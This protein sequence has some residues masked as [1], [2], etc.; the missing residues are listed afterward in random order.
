MRNK[1]FLL[2]LGGLLSAAPLL[3]AQSNEIGLQLGRTIHEGRRFE[4]AGLPQNVFK[5]DNGWAGGLVY[6]RK[7]LGGKGAALNLHVPFFLL[8]DRIP[9]PNRFAQSS[10]DSSKVSGFITPGLQVRFLQPFFLQPYLFGGVG[11]ARVGQ[12][13]A[14]PIGGSLPT[15]RLQLESK[16]TWG[17]SVG[18]GLDIMLGR[19]F[20]LR[21]EA[22]GLTSGG[23]DRV[24]PGLTLDEPGARWAATAGLVIRF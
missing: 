24:I 16:G 1:S 14:A 2:V 23:R 4:F 21:G 9:E 15:S 13:N 6:N 18:G 12:V 5:E 7:M 20:G 19:H 10:G 11:Y 17:A 3:L 8:Q 22:R